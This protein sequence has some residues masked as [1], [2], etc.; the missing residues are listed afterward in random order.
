MVLIIVLIISY[1][2]SVFGFQSCFPHFRFSVSAENFNFGA[3]LFLGD[4]IYTSC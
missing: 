1:G 2:V 4:E 3:S